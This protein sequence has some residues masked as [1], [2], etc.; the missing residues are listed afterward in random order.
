MP[1]LT[2]QLPRYHKHKASGQ[3]VVKFDGKLHYLGPHGSKGSKIEYK[4]LVAEWLTS[5]RHAQPI[6]DS[7]DLML[8]HN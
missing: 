5:G 8:I 4:R 1:K 2:Q 7:N 3:A 6:S